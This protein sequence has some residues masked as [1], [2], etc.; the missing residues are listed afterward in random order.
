MRPSFMDIERLKRQAKANLATGT[1]H[2]RQWWARK[3]ERPATDPLFQNQTE[4]A[5]QLEWF[6]DL[7]QR[8]EEILKNLENAKGGESE[9]LLKQL[10]AIN[11]ALDIEVEVQDDLVEYWEAE[12]L[13]GRVPDLDMMPEDL[14]HM[15]DAR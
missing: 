13:A 14:E 2:L 3:Y 4:G 10:N 6:E 5:L 7:Y 8:R 1:Y 12:V 15:R 9:T 11:Q